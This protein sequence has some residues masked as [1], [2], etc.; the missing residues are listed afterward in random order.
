M[1]RKNIL[2][3]IALITVFALAL[4]ACGSDDGETKAPNTQ[5]DASDQPL[6][7]A[8]WSM[9]ATTWSSPNGATVNLTA[10]PNAHIDGQTASF[11]IRL[12][13]ENVETIPCEWDGTHYTA[14]AELNAADGYCYYVILTA[15]DGTQTEVAV[16]TPTAPTD[17]ALINMEAALNSYCSL[18]VETSSFDGSKLTI[19]QGHIQVQ[20]PRIFDAGQTITCSEAVL[21]LSLNNEE[22]ARQALP[23]PEADAIGRYDLDVTS[24]S[25]TVPA[26]E[27]DQQLS[28]RLDVT[29]SNGQILTAP[30]TTWFYA[31]GALL[32]SVG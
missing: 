14:S 20:P 9:D 29:L 7:L 30:G 28:L 13:G 24:T 26:M 15:A 19:T 21:V 5:I 3:L 18:T 2:I 31:D 16:N 6:G 32:S 1:K 4:T 17:E 10:T 27:D 22:I 8:D 11:V 23:L 25:F 12:E